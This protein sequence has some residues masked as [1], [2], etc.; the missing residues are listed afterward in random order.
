VTINAATLMKWSNYLKDI[1][2]TSSDCHTYICK[3]IEFAA[4]NFFQNQ[5]TGPNEFD[6]AFH[7]A[8]KK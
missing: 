2:K 8:F 4:K 3:R 1:T 5:T 6:G 7:Q